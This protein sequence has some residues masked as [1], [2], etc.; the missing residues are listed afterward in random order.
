MANVP[1]VEMLGVRLSGFGQG[2]GLVG[3]PGDFTPPARFVRAVA[4]TQSATPTK[5]GPKRR[6]AGVSHF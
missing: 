3:L 4:F 1:P 2:N 5:N 6:T